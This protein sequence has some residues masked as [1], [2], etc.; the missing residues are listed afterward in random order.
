MT[1]EE[2]ISARIGEVRTDTFDMTFGEIANLHA[3]DHGGC[4]HPG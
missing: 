4:R 3:N 1:L 2:E